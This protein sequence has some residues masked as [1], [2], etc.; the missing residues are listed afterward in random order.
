MKKPLTFLL[1]FFLV[2]GAVFAGDKARHEAARKGKKPG[3][4]KTAV[5]PPFT[6]TKFHQVGNLWLAVTNFGMFGNEGNRPS[7]EFPANSNIDY[8]F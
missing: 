5:A 8:L 1:L 7:C 4:D 2:A 3:F 6:Q